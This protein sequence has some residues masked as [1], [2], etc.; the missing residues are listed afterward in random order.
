M[1]AYSFETLK[2][3]AE[4]IGLTGKDIAQYISQQQ[5][6]DRDERARVRDFE[7]LKFEAEL[8]KAKYEAETE[9]AKYEYEL[10]VARS[11]NIPNF[12]ASDIACRPTLP[13]LRMGKTSLLT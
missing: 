10:E 8:A 6:V 1:E 11:N 13:V 12:S 7:K 4:S 2:E 9:K 3:Q 5:A